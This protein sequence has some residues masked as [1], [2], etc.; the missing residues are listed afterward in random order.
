MSRIPHLVLA[1]LVTASLALSACGGDS[2]TPSGDAAFCKDIEKLDDIDLG[3]DIGAAAGILTDLAEKAP[4][5]EIRDALLVIAPIFE[6]LAN[7]DQAD[8]EAMSGILEMMSSPEV[9][10]ASEV[11][12]RFGTDICGFEDTSESTPNESAP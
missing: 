10:A 5:D 8:A 3:D 7:T 4:N 6:Q 2:S 11:L 12:D 1:P 9:T